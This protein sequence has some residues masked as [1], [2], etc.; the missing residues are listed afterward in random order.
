MSKDAVNANY[1]NPAGYVHETLT[2]S[3]TFD[4]A[5][6][7]VDKPSTEFS[8]FP[9]EFLRYYTILHLKNFQS[10]KLQNILKIHR[11]DLKKEN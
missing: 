9:G 2:V 3:K 8:W 11:R 6:K 5:V 7:M 1:C 10:W 4:T